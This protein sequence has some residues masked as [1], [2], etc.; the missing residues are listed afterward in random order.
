MYKINVV[1]FTWSWGYTMLI[2]TVW[3]P[4]ITF[5]RWICS[6]IEL[7]LTCPGSTPSS[8]FLSS[9]LLSLIADSVD[10]AATA[11][12]SHPSLT[13][14]YRSLASRCCTDCSW[15]V[16]IIYV[17]FV[18]WILS[19][20]AVSPARLSRSVSCSSLSQSDEEFF[21]FFFGGASLFRLQPIEWL[22]TKW[23]YQVHLLNS[24]FNSF[25]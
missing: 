17:F 19:A 13:H 5:T 8:L 20:L 4:A 11:T 7:V 2:V 22:R 3:N 24:Y 6:Q 9:I 16:L 25:L 18:E 1:F 23:V 10:P 14:Y 15:H 12:W 21:L